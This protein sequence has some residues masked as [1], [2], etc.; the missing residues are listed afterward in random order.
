MDI[1]GNR[2]FLLLYFFTL[3]QSQHFTMSF[4]KK[5]TKEFEELKSSFKDKDEPKK[6]QTSSHEPKHEEQ[7]DF[8]QSSNASYGQHQQQYGQPSHDQQQHYGQQQS[9]GQFGSYPPPPP[10]QSH[11]GG[12]P[13]LPPGWIMQW[14]ANSQRNYYVEQ[15]TGKTQWDPPA[16]NQYPPPSQHG[17]GGYS[18]PPSHGAPYGGGS[19]DGSRGYGDQHQYN[20]GYGGAPGYDP[21]HA[22][23]PYNPNMAG[24]PQKKDNSTRNMLLAGGAGLAGGALI[25][26]ALGK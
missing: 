14:D 1:A 5:L 11:T 7:R 4:L 10:S 23:G 8:G 16:H 2:S 9:Y 21:R 20:Q 13:S 17:P 15:A 26:N 6:E 12:P 19:H 3:L 24:H 22:T 18:S 25:A